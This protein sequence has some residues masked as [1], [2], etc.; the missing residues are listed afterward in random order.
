MCVYITASHIVTCC[1][2]YIYCPYILLF[3]QNEINYT[4]NS[5]TGILL[6]S[7]RLRITSLYTLVTCNDNNNN[8]NNI[9]FYLIFLDSERSKEEHIGFFVREHFFV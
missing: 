9:Q 6:W 7:T 1:N 3:I 8:N 2:I 4:N 5:C